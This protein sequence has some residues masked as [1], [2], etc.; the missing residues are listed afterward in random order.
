MK[1]AEIRQKGRRTDEKTINLVDADSDGQV[2]LY[3][4]SDLEYDSV[5]ELAEVKTCELLDLFESVNKS[6]S[7]NEELS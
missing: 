6:I 2:L 1:T 7:V 4:E 5:I 3:H